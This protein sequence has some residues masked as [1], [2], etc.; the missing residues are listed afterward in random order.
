MIHP[1]D[2]HTDI[3]GSAIGGSGIFIYRMGI[4]TG[5]KLLKIT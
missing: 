2:V 4:V 5:F 3:A 1:V